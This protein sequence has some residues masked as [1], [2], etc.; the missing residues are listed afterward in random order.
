MIEPQPN[1]LELKAMLNDMKN[2]CMDLAV[3][4]EA[5]TDEDDK[6]TVRCAIQMF[7]SLATLIAEH[8]CESACA[9]G[10]TDSGKYFYKR[11]LWRN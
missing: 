5:L 8:T 11:W 4:Q 10:V 1:A 7:I 2:V 3:I 6:E 9:T